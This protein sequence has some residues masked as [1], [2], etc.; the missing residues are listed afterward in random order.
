MIVAVSSVT[1][2]HAHRQ[3]HYRNTLRMC[4]GGIIIYIPTGK[5]H[6]VHWMSSNK[7]YTRHLPAIDTSMWSWGE[8]NWGSTHPP[9]HPP[10]GVQMH[11]VKFNFFLD[12]VNWLTLTISVL[13]HTL[14][15]VTPYRTFFLYASSA[16][17]AEDW[18][19]ILR[20]KLDH[21]SGLETARRE[22][23]V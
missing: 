7:Y 6:H 16:Q 9:T 4:T 12:T 2:T 13:A 21:P 19:K 14:R 11:V 5:G 17:E 15:L 1:D 3:N 20:W 22:G 10:Y 23:R 8:C 18:I